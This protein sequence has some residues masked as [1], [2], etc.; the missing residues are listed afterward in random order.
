MQSEYPALGDMLYLCSRTCPTFLCLG[1]V[2][3]WSCRFGVVLLHVV[4]DL[5]FLFSEMQFFAG[6]DFV[7]SH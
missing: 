5:E 7:P 2:L 6:G 4:A 3:E 1:L